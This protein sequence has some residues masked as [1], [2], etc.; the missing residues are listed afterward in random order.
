MRIFH[1]LR[2]AAREFDILLYA[3]TEGEIAEAD[4]APVLE[5][6]ATVYLVKKPRYREPRWSTLAPPEVCEYRSPAMQELWRARQADVAQVEY[7][8]LASYGGEILVEHDVT[9]DLYAQVRAR[10]KTVAT[11]WDWWRWRRFE[12]R[13]VQR[14]KQV[15]VMADKDRE[16]LETQRARVIENGVDLDRFDPSPETPGRRLLF[17]GSFRHFPNI[18]AFRFLTEEIFPQLP[19][20]ELTVVAGPDPWP[21]WRNHTGTLH[22]PEHPRIRLL[23]F[24]AD[25]RPLYREANIVVVPTLESAGTNVKVL[26]ALAMERAVVSTP[27]GCAGLGLEPGRTAWIADSAA[28]L[29]EGIMKL[30]D[31]GALRARIARAGRTHAKK[32]F[33]WRA[34][35][36]RQRG[37]LR[38]LAGDPLVLRPAATDDLDAIARIQTASPSSSQWEPESY[39]RFDC[40][41][42]ALRGNRTLTGFLVSRPTAPGEREILNLAVDPTQ[43]RR[44]IAQRLLEEELNRGEGSWFLEV[45]ESNRAAIRLYQTWGFRSVG[46]RKN[47]YNNPPEAGIVMRF[48]S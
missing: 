32:H 24:V 43:R 45:R 39:L 33:D 35:G 26:E 22:P 4:L 28:G 3:F 27:S 10:R 40:L 36:R 46:R 1:L 5:F 20:A 16:L 30:L 2:E 19:D 41:V 17:I 29:A 25:V 15:V 48:L 6:V 23:E 7:T 9:Y 38:E 21:H 34:I 14:Y 42:A 44:G 11:W 47:Y 18:V 37:L 8:Y 31:D 13:A 12:L